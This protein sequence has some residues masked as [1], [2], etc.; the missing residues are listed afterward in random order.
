[1]NTVGRILD[2]KAIAALVRG[3]VKAG[4]EALKARSGLQVGLAVVRVGDD[5][6]SEIYVRGKIRDCQEV[7]FTS[8]EHHLPA[9]TTQAALMALIERLNRDPAVHGMLVQLPLPPQ[10]DADAAL[11]AVDPAKDV[12][13]FHPL[14]AGKLMTG[15][16]GPRACT[17]L[18]ILRMLDEARV[19]I[20]GRRAVVIGRSNI[21]G[22]PMSMLLLERHATVV[23][24][25]SR[26]A[27]LEGEVR[28]GEIVVAAVGRAAVI[29]GAWIKEG[30]TVID[31]GMNRLP[32]GKLVGDVEY[33][34]AFERAGWITPVPGGV[35]PMTRA[36]LLSNTLAAARGS[37][38]PR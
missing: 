38:G 5:A 7:G 33:A 19:E 22:K 3:E 8:W 36:A 1:V 34:A 12:D 35:G 10:I 32:D 23:M 30:A 17:P 15:R 26:T 37:S 11:L 24:C 2:G 28:R 29:R 16:P 18:G 9:D 31:V 13:G 27:D 6:A 14:N 21:V 4:A 25:H 20:A